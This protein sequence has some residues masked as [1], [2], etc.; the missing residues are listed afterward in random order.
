MEAL[1]FLEVVGRD[2]R[3]L[4]RHPV[5]AFPC[6]VGRA[7]DNHVILDD[8]LVAGHH[9]ELAEVQPGRYSVVDL[10]SRNGT[11]LLPSRR[12]VAHAEVGPDDLIGIGH[13]Q[14][15]LRP[16]EYRVPPEADAQRR[17]RVRLPAVAALASL[18]A[19]AA[20]SGTLYQSSG[21]TP[22]ASSLLTVLL[23]AATAVLVWSA[24][25]ALVSR[26]ATSQWCYLA[27]LTIA[28]VAILA[29]TGVD[30]LVGA[31]TFAFGWA[32]LREWDFLPMSGVFAYQCYRHLRLASRSPRRR[33]A[34]VALAV[35]LV[36]F[37]SPALLQ[38]LKD[39]ENVSRMAYFTDIRPPAWRLT[40]G[41]TPERFIARAEKLQGRLDRSL[42]ER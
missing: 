28:G 4:S 2:G 42:L 16:R 13:T 11:I 14:L 30:E 39:R 18:G 1:A 41:V 37:G 38:S 5:P 34:L 21:E 33:L 12:G 22:E 25:W 36:C 7:Y 31:L 10:G 40:P 3:V 8:P 23:L 26:L 32:G 6:R 20:V 17:S 9:L 19:G 27:H 35:S 29:F 24:G 15:R